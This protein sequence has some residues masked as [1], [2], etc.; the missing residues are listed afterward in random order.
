[1]TSIG[2]RP[3]RGFLLVALSLIGESRGTSFWEGFLSCSLTIEGGSCSETGPSTWRLLIFQREIGRCLNVSVRGEG[4]SKLA[5]S[6]WWG[7]PLFWGAGGAR[8]N[9]TE[10][11][12]R[13]QPQKKVCSPYEFRGSTGFRVGHSR[14]EANSQIKS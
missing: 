13:S 10:S 9:F 4:C 11:L 1:M 5:S 2:E 7:W 3:E 6:T 8:R 14:G 12:C